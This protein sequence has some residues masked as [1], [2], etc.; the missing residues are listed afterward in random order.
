MIYMMYLTLWECYK[1]LGSQR[2][3]EPLQCFFCQNPLMGVLDNFFSTGTY[4]GICSVS[5]LKHVMKSTTKKWLD[6]PIF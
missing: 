4:T 1:L 5:S 6:L 3:R 2:G